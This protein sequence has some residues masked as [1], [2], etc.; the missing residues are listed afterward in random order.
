MLISCSK[1][2]L[3]SVSKS[4]MYRKVL[5]KVLAS[6]LFCFS[7]SFMNV[8]VVKKIKVC[9]K[10]S[11]VRSHR[12]ANRLLKNPISDLDVDVVY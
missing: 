7:L 2:G 10:W 5:L 4:L 6:W 3:F 11:A 1:F 12:Y 9:Q 8:F